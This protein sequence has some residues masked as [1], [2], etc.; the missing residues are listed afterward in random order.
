M[1]STT[2]NL[3]FQNKRPPNPYIGMGV[4][5]G[6]GLAVAGG[7]S[8]FLLIRRRKIYSSIK[9]EEK[10]DITKSQTSVTGF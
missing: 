5:I 4:G 1:G 9:K 7:L 6:V 2:F 10:E 8:A 3:N